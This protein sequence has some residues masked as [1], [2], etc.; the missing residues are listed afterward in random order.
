MVDHLLKGRFILGVGAGILRSDA[1]VL[2]ILDQ[3]RTAMFRESIRTYRRIMDRKRALR[4]HRQILEY[5][6]GENPVAG[7]KVLATFSLESDGH[8]LPSLVR[9]LLTWD[10]MHVDPPVPVNKIILRDRRWGTVL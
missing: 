10:R 6:H 9:R 4:S 1:E 7:D 8:I 5:L 3:D 2:G